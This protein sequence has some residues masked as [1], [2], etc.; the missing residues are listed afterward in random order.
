LL[1]R[2]KF[3]W[4]G[5][6]L[7]QPDW[8]EHS[9][10]IA[11]EVESLSGSFHIHYMINASSQALTFDIPLM[12]GSRTWRRWIDTSLPSPDNIGSWED[13]QVVPG[14]TYQL[15]DHSLAVLVFQSNPS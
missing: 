15:M 1:S 11:I 3:K 9:H 10:A 8:S 4:H 2:A 14:Q 5:I 13:G 12:N 7:N 6:K